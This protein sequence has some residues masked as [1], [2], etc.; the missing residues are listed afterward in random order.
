[1]R[2]MGTQTILGACWTQCVLYLVYTLIGINSSSWNGEITRDELTWCSEMMVELWMKKRYGGYRW[3]R[4]ST[5]DSIREFRC[6]T[7]LTEL[8]KPPV[9]IFTCQIGSSTCLI[10]N[11]SLS[12]TQNFLQSQLVMINFPI[13]LS[14]PQLY[15]HPSIP[16]QVI[17]HYLS[18]AGSCVNTQ[19][20]IHWVLRT[21]R[22]A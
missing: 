10:G 3:A 14:C 19:Y 18:M 21:L 4:Y 17:P 9:V 6:K 13:S 11:C 1:M 15:H 12:N 7:W 5:C 2:M 16:S 22:T 8:R 20:N